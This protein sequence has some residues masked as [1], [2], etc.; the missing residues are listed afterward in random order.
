MSSLTCPYNQLISPYCHKYV[1][2]N[3]A[4]II[5]GNGLSP[6]WCHA[7]TWSNV[8]LLSIGL[9]GPNFSEIWIW[10]LS[11]QLKKCIS[12]YCLPK[13]WPFWPEGDE[14][15]SLDMTKLP[16]LIIRQSLKG[17]NL[18]MFLNKKIIGKE[19]SQHHTSYWYCLLSALAH[20]HEHK[21]VTWGRCL[22]LGSVGKLKVGQG[23]FPR[24]FRRLFHLEFKWPN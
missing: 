1:P 14:L 5:Q 20:K 22:V 21:L 15:S 11:F 10:I 24:N 17:R 8:G 16:D 3:K 23:S 9:L 7:I 12:I 2:V 18:C 19:S 6:I 4:I 13:R